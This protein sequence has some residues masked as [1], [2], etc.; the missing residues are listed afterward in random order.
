MVAPPNGRFH[1][2]N[3]STTVC[4][5]ESKPNPYRMQGNTDMVFG[6][7]IMLIL[8]IITTGIILAMT[9]TSTSK[10]AI[11]TSTSSWAIYIRTSSLPLM[12]PGI[13]KSLLNKVRLN[14]QANI[15]HDYHLPQSC[16]CYCSSGTWNESRCWSH[17]VPLSGNSS[18]ASATTGSLSAVAASAHHHQDTDL[19]SN[20]MLLIRSNL[21]FFRYFTCKWLSTHRCETVHWNHGGSVVIP[22]CR[23]RSFSRRT[24]NHLFINI[25]LVRVLQKAHI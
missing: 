3:V 17:Q 19:G 15:I 11:S 24:W 18:C 6:L 5:A 22:S 25:F 23:E 8:L 2:D 14:N 16:P 21:C 10:T 4:V 13:N 12:L 20:R 7:V 9:M 1:Y